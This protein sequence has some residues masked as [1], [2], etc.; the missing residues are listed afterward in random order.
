MLSRLKLFL[1]RGI[2]ILFLIF[3]YFLA[4]LSIYPLLLSFFVL[5]IRL[6]NDSFS[7]KPDF[8]WLLFFLNSEVEYVAIAEHGGGGIK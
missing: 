1:I 4:Y 7:L 8:Q 6:L 5:V 2:S 3:L